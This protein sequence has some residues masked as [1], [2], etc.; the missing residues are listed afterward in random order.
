MKSTEDIKGLGDLIAG[1]TK[2]T[3]IKVLVKKIAGE[4]CGCEDRREK[5]NKK[6]PFKNKL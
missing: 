6:F 2:S 4:N 1:F 5:L 3:G